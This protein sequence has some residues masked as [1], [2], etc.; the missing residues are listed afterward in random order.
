MVINA[1]AYTQV[2]RAETEPELAMTRNALAPGS[3][4][5]AAR[6]V[7]A[8]FVHISTDFVF[9]GA[10]RTP[11]APEAETRPLSVY[12]RSKRQGELA[13][14]AAYPEA[15]ILRTAWI[16]ASEG[17]NFLT[18]MLARMKRNEPLRVV[19]D[20]IGTPTLAASAAGCLWALA[21]APT[22][23]VWHFTDGGTASWYD[24]ALAIGEEAADAGILPRAPVVTPVGS[25]DFPSPVSRPPYSALDC[26]RTWELIGTPPH[27]RENLR[28][29]I[30][31]L[32]S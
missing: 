22:S 1:A 8:R 23:G 17:H 15:L 11:Y 9:D 5:A 6:E 27:W 7:G 13:V 29:T 25:A 30:R 16:Y 32:A 10:L 31:A 21:R 26:R 14:L 28:R 4:A 19:N 12:G 2:E 24:F 18:A 3:L 20:Q